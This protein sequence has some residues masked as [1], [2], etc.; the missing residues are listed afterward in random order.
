M[1]QQS[2]SS[3]IGFHAHL[4][5]VRSL[6]AHH[7]Q[8]QDGAAASHN[9]LCN[10][11]TACRIAAVA[12][13]AIERWSMQ[14]KGFAHNRASDRSVGSTCHDMHVTCKCWVHRGEFKGTPAKALLLMPPICHVDVIPPNLWNRL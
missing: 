12:V 9:M 7:H 6:G 5:G 4:S 3:R 13:Q 11:V 8:S 2:L 14:V 10:S 1:A